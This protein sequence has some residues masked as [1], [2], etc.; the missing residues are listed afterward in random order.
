MKNWVESVFD[1]YL[2]AE[3]VGAWS[4]E[5]DPNPV[6]G[7]CNRDDLRGWAFWI[8]NGCKC[9]EIYRGRRDDFGRRMRKVWGRG[10]MKLLKDSI[11]PKPDH[12]KQLPRVG[13]FI[14]PVIENSVGTYFRLINKVTLDTLTF[15][16]GY[17][18]MK[19]MKLEEIVD[20]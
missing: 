8:P 19:P 10:D 17:P 4:Y 15:G 2:K 12:Q 9:P 3:V 7:C 6:C 1:A 16:D 13:W 11:K 5:L 18:R 14:S 20:V